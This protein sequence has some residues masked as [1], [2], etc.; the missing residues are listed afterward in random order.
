[1]RCFYHA[2]HEAV[3][4]CKN[5]NRGVC[6]ECAREVGDS[7][8]CRN[9]CEDKVAEVNQ[10]WSRAG[11]TRRA[12]ALT[13]R[14]QGIVALFMG[15]LFACM[16][17]VFRPWEAHGAFGILGYIFMAF[18]FIIAVSGLMNLRTATRF[19]FPQQTKDSAGY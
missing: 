16:G 18:G 4:I 19:D 7:L 9:R 6:R 11:D 1:M 3:G 17:A 5:C 8:A 12:A 13:Y 15:I 14:R 2:S 10:L